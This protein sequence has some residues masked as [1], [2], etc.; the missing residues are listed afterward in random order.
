MAL[1][2]FCSKPGCQALCNQDQRFCKDHQDL[3]SSRADDNKLYDQFVRHGRDKRYTEFYHSHE[4]EVTSDFIIASYKGIDLYAYYVE[5][6]M[7]DADTAH[8][9]IELKD[10][11][12]KRLLHGNL[13][14]VSDNSHRIIH[15]RY[16][17]DKLGT[18]RLLFE[19]IQRWNREMRG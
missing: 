9:I 7:I 12:S 4:W 16:R 14:P 6:S 13:I 1:M 3:N 10:D 2:R 18:Q 19:L 11:W 5:E 15:K 8:H 17:R